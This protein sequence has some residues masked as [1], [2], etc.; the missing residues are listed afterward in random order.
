MIQLNDFCLCGEKWNHAAHCPSYK[1]RLLLGERFRLLAE[2]VKEYADEAHQQTQDAGT[3][4]RHHAGRRQAAREIAEW[5]EQQA[6][7]VER[8][9]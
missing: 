2:R 9:S 5:I 6:D 4:W 1:I 8:A 7:E 3:L